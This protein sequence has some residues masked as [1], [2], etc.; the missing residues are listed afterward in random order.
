MRRRGPR[1]AGDLDA[2]GPPDDLADDGL[3]DDD[4]EALDP[5]TG[6][7]V[8][9]PTAHRAAAPP[10]RRNKRAVRLYALAAFLGALSLFQFVA[11][12]H[13]YDVGHDLREIEA[14]WR[15][16]VIVDHDRAEAEGVIL[17]AFVEFDRAPDL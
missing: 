9:L 2:L 15:T 5:T 7:P 16:A 11:A 17:A 4:L 3:A 12:K 13:A 8:G 10:Q 6:E 1:S 14:V